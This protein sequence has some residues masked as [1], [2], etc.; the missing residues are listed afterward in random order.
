MAAARIGVTGVWHQGMIVAAFLAELGHSVVGVPT[1]E[2]A[3]AR[4]SAAE[5]LVHE[6]GLPGLLRRNLDA[7]RLSFTASVGSAVAGAELVFLSLDTPVDDRDRPQL[8]AVLRLAAEI[9]A[10][11]T[12]DCILCVTAQVE[13]GTSER[14]RTIVRERSSHEIGLAYVP[15]FL[16]LG[17]AVETFRDADRFVVGCDEPAVAARV[18]ALFAPLERPIVQTSVATAE[19]AKHASNAFLATSISFANELADL[20]EVV[21]ADAAE[22]GRILRLDARIG[23]KAYLTPGVGFAGATLGRDVR[24]LQ[25]LGTEHGV[26]TRVADAVMTVNDERMAMVVRRLE[27]ELGGLDG[28][29]VA[30]IGL[31]Y[32]AG[33]DTLRRA[34]SLELAAALRERGAAVTGFDPLARVGDLAG[35]PPLEQRPSLLEAAAG[36]DALVVLVGLPELEALDLSGVEAAMRGD[37]VL[38]TTGRLPVDA[39]LQAGLR[40][41]TTGRGA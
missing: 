29:R 21:G 32:K 41:L 12:G 35:P 25:A 30:L 15:E 18:T 13:V 23:P 20:C 34:L 28:R 22:V 11:L 33:T 24:T 9:G 38:D 26:P 40:L 3:A 2:A 4:L 1:S 6:P 5:P 8:D 10:G 19:V 16:R 17:E 31:A 14:L 36:C 27:R 39:A 37:V 7:G